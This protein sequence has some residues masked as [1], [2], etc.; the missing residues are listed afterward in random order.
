M[1]GGIISFPDSESHVMSFRCMMGDHIQK[2]WHWKEEIDTLIKQVKIHPQYIVGTTCWVPLFIYKSCKSNENIYQNGKKPIYLRKWYKS[3]ILLLKITYTT[4][5]CKILWE[6]HF[7]RS[8]ILSSWKKFWLH[9][10]D[11][12]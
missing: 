12:K 4:L 6:P 5:Q 1:Y 7:V 3:I 2:I 8:Y 10:C 11:L 9:P